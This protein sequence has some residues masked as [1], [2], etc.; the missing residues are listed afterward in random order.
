MQ[1]ALLFTARNCAFAV[2]WQKIAPCTAVLVGVGVGVDVCDV[3][4]V[5]EG[6]D[7]T[8]VVGVVDGDVVGV[9]MEHC[10]NVPSEYEDKALFSHETA[11][12]HFSLVSVLTKPEKEQSTSSSLVASPEPVR[13]YLGCFFCVMVV[14]MRV[15]VF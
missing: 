3:V 2:L 6:V 14:Y 12:L 9:V 7:V 1:L 8:V 5:V 11:C 10:V 15:F 13:V 4:T